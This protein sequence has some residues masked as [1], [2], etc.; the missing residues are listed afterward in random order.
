MGNQIEMSQQV[1]TTN[2]PFDNI[3]FCDRTLAIWIGQGGYTFITNDKKTQNPNVVKYIP[4]TDIDGGWTYIHF[5]YG[6]RQNKRQ[7]S[8]L[9]AENIK[10]SSSIFR[11]VVGGRDLDLY[12]KWLCC[13]FQVHSLLRCLHS[14]IQAWAMSK[15]YQRN[16]LLKLRLLSHLQGAKPDP[17]CW[18]GDERIL[19]S[20]VDQPKP[21]ADI[22][23]DSD[24]L[25]EDFRQPVPLYNGKKEPWY[26][27]SR[28]TN[29]VKY[30]NVVMGDRVLAT[31]LGQE[32]FTFIT[33]Y[34]KT[35][36]PKFN[37]A[38]PYGDI[39]G[40]WTYIYYIYSQIENQGVGFLKYGDKDYKSVT[41]DHNLY[42]CQVPR[43]IFKGGYGSF[44]ETP[45]KFENFACKCNLIPK[46]DC[47]MKAEVVPIPTSKKYELSSAVI[48]E[49][50]SPK[51]N[52]F[53]IEYSISG[54][55]V[56]IHIKLENKNAE[57]LGDRTL[58]VW[59]SPISDGIYAF[60]TYTY[61]NLNGAGNPNLYKAH[62]IWQ[63]SYIM[64]FHKVW[65]NLRKV[66]RLLIQMPTISL[67]KSFILILVKVVSILH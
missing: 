36:N 2:D 46:V 39:Q 10:Q 42:T 27:L 43:A 17:F 48:N 25:K 22:Q 53:P 1:L 23:V 18:E 57:R 40:V 6:L 34:V 12:I 66:K 3:R 31:W 21:L 24:K 33:N 14:S 11:L 16:Q 15:S 30:G 28:L 61:T 38:I 32:G 67:M 49:I 54:W 63:G 37:K 4:I 64:A 59:A 55:L 7:D 60:A 45:E 51:E 62:T 26:F 56:Q 13:R 19:N 29:N 58:A 65:F 20:A 50:V 47:V 41:L 5:S 9:L 8:Y 44:Y 35:T 52:P